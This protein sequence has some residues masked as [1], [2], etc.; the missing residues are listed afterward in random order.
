MSY[1][2]ANALSTS[3]SKR[4]LSC[5][6]LDQLSVDTWNECCSL[7]KYDP[8]KIEREDKFLVDGLRMGLFPHQAITVFWVFQR[9]IKHVRWL[10]IADEMD[11]EK[12]LEFIRV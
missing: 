11:L 3:R 4:L 1:S 8:H 7:F 12:M 5:P 10:F 2:L 6:T 9:Y